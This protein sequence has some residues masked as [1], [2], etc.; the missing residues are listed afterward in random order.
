MKKRIKDKQA[1][2]INNK[3]NRHF[4]EEFKRSKVKDLTKGIISISEFCKLYKVSR[5]SV[6]KWIYLYSEFE[7]G[8]TT[9]V[10]MESEEYKAKLLYE[11]IAVLERT[12]GQKQLEIDFLNK[13]LE[14]ASSEMDLDLK[15]KYGIV[16]SNGSDGTPK[17]MTTG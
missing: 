10:Q 15:K 8:V 1:L 14:V 2:V 17:N 3:Y 6:Y 12:I 11:R 7:R 16:S 4:S 9:V 13:T 5:T